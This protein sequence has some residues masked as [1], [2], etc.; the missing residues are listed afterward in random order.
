MSI[1]FIF[2]RDFY[3]VKNS[4]VIGFFSFIILMILHHC[5]LTYIL[6]HEKSA[7]ILIF[8]SLHKVFFFPSGSFL[9]FLFV[10]GVKQFDFEVSV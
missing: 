9:G 5:L 8:V 3:W 4:N 2:E 6:S 7:V 10:T 1:N